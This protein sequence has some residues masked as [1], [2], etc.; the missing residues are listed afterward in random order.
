[1][2]KFLAAFFVLYA[3]ADVSVLQAYCG[4][5]SLGIPPADHAILDVDVSETFS[6]GNEGDVFASISKRNVS[7]SPV[8]A[9]DS[10]CQ[11]DPECFGSC[12]HVA[13]SLT[14]LS[15]RDEAILPGK[16]TIDY[17]QNQYLPT[18]LNPLFQPP[19]QS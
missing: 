1:M 15:F 13:V 14:F 11:G 16:D 17:H 19:K 8:P 3:L 6:P 10:P 4:N 18:D 2:T 5:E 9:P 12:S 7:I